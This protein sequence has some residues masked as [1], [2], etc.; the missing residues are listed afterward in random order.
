MADHPP[1]KMVQE[2]NREIGEVK[3]HYEHVCDDIAGIRKVLE[4]GWKEQVNAALGDLRR[5]VTDYED[6]KK[7]EKKIKNDV[8][9]L[10][11][12]SWVGKLFDISFKRGVAII[13]GIIIASALTNAGTWGFFKTFYYKEKPSMLEDISKHLN[14]QKLP[15]GSIIIHVKEIPPEEIPA[16]RKGKQ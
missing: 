5:L 1:C 8:D 15:D 4:N 6:M 2:L 12:Y 7:D 13:V 16:E 9:N 10:K 14:V 3:T 11:K